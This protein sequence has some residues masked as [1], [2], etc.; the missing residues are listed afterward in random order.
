MKM[1]RRFALCATIIALVFTT[2]ARANLLD[3][4]VGYWPFD[5]DAR[6]Y[7]G[8]G[9]H[10]TTHGVSLT[11]DR[12]GNSGNA[13]QF[14]EGKFIS[15]PA[16]S[17]LNKI[18][19]FSLSLWVKVLSY[20]QEEEPST[21]RLVALASKGDS[22]DMER[23]FGVQLGL[24]DEEGTWFQCVSDERLSYPGIT[25]GQWI[26]IVICR[27]NLLAS[28]YLN[29]ARVGFGTTR[30]LSKNAGDFEI[31]RDIRGSMEYLHGAMDEIVL[32]NRALSSSEVHALYNCGLKVCMVSFAANGGAGS[33]G[34]QK[35]LSG[36][37]LSIPTNQ[38]TRD[39]YIFN[40]WATSLER[41]AQGIVDYADEALIQ[42]DS[43]KTLYAVWAAPALTLEAE[44]ADWSH[45]SITLRCADA[46]TSGAA[47]SYSLFYKD[48]KGCTKAVEEIGAANV[49]VGADGF[50]HLTDS[51]FSSRLG[52][53]PPVK[54]FVK[55][56]NGRWSAECVTRNRYLLSVGFD[57]YRL[58]WQ[59]GLRQ[60]LTDAAELKRL[61]E[62]NGEFQSS[63]TKLLRNS[64]ATADGIRNTMT[65]FA[66]RTQPGDLFVFYIATH[67]GDYSTS[68]QA[69]LAAYDT[70]YPVS[71]LQADVRKFDSGVAVACIVMACHSA[72]MTG[73]VDDFSERVNQWLV[74]CGFAQCLG[75]V[76][77]IA[78]CESTQSSYNT[79]N[80]TMFGQSFIDDGLGGGY[81]DGKLYGVDF[82]GEA[83]EGG[84]SDGL[85][86]LGELGRYAGAFAKGVSD[87]KASNVKLENDWLLDRIV[88]GKRTGSTSLSRPGIPT[89]PSATQG[90]TR[91]DIGWT[92]SGNATIYRIYRY[93]L[94]APKQWEWIGTCHGNA[95]SDDTTVLIRE[96]GY[97]I[98]AVNPI[99]V[100]DLSDVAVGSRGTS[101]ILKFLGSFLDSASASADAYDTIEKAIA[102]NGFTYGASYV[103][104]L[105]PTDPTSK[106]ETTFSIGA[107]GKPVVTWTPDLNEGGT[108][109]ERVYRV[110]GAKELGAAAQWDDVTDVE[111]PDAEGYRFFKAAVEMP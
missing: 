28:L 108:K 22:P 99:G 7:S 27:E 107:D 10:G 9:N 43:D 29:G 59:K 53:I 62:R 51:G 58:W 35:V 47:H 66:G 106:F 85:V 96:Y 67:G 21:K 40:G 4:L 65:D 49:T 81:A 11:S 71:A 36:A 94:D 3:G 33:M 102:P 25:L 89:N 109:S 15:I 98:M 72:S 105:D 24:T 38:F 83:Y 77:W 87:K 79:A 101:K 100:S 97:R 60:A 69:R 64:E 104:G 23:Q 8:N 30:V 6:D 34:G 5:G 91:I 73:G 26:H 18:G 1:N 41:A 54:Y 37:H 16:N 88:L 61:C 76:A 68:K 70:Y 17:Q 50:A 111:D 110:L 39:G 93:P 2:A 48:E 63:N 20:H 82:R 12:H 32:Y 90:D 45:G 46:D 92:V 42:I 55:D 57:S 14:G 52:G 19:D 103:A 86:T 13:Y 74:A 95:F 56:E 44:S 31:G 80:F 75:N 84:N 78:S